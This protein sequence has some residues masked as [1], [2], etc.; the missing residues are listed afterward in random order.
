ME[1]LSA[2]HLHKAFGEKVLLDGV[3]F[4]IET[5]ERIGLV[6]VNGTGKST[7]LKIISEKEETDKGELKHPKDFTVSYLAQ[8]A[9][10]SEDLTVLDEIYMGDL[11]LIKTLH[12]Y[13]HARMRLEQDPLS[14][15]KLK[16]FQLAQEQMD[17]E[18]AWDHETQ[19][20]TILSKLGI[21]DY[22]QTIDALSGGQ[23]K[24][25]A[26]AKAL[27]QPADL[28]I[29][30]EPT[31]HLDHDSIEWLEQYLP[32]Y[33][34]ALIIVT[35]DRYFLNRV[36]NRIYELDKGQMYRYVGNYETYLEKKA[37]RLELAEQSKQKHQNILKKEIAWLK[38]GVKARTTKQKARIDRVLEMKK[39]TF[40]KKQR[41]VDL[42]LRGTR[43]GDEVFEL[44]DV[45]KSFEGETLFQPFSFLIKPDDRIGIVG[46]NGSGKSTLLNMLAGRMVPDT[47]HIAV[48]ETVKIGYYTQDHSEMDEDLKIIDYIRKTADVIHTK[49]D[50]VI[51]AEQMLERFLFNRGDQ[52]TFI[53]RL[54]GGE[55]RR[56]YLL[57]VLMQEPNVLLLDEPTNDLDTETLAILEN[58]LD[59]FPGVVISVSHDRYFL[60]RTADQLF[61]FTDEGIIN[62]FYGDYSDYLAERKEDK[63]EQKVMNKE[64]SAP[65]KKKKKLSY[66]EQK[67][68]QTIEDEISVL[69]EQIET[70]KQAVIEAGSDS[71][72]VRIAYDEQLALESAL[73]EKMERWEELSLL[74]ESLDN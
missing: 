6:G 57:H 50:Q 26:L 28:L 27:I 19:A 58:Y 59:E 63:K 40:E 46:K 25:V 11:P 55:K 43:L 68:W 3:S 69:E 47:G 34:G 66:H 21:N 74:V 61:V 22:H 29:L 45:T 33:K 5:G 32:N 1:I 18:H 53:R 72:K 60:D 24:R 12:Q 37:E 15:Q 9:E 17:R 41:E 36:T 42:N 13:E 38:A 4:S 10:L 30:D 62:T 49:D 67:E 35:H 70:K 31:N 52:Q 23:K 7:F 39:Q 73:E 20:K 56:L 71:E 16:A 48:G 2:H 51:T 8:E 14:E 54:S 44:T 65:V 64:P